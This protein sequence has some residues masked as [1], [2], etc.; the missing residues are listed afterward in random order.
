M[1]EDGVGL[2]QMRTVR[3]DGQLVV[4]RRSCRLVKHSSERDDAVRLLRDDDTIVE[5]FQMSQLQRV[6]LGAKTPTMQRAVE[7]V[8]SSGV[9]ATDFVQAA[10]WTEL[11]GKVPEAKCL[12]VIY[13]N[14]Y[15][16]F[17]AGFLSPILHPPP[18]LP[19]R[20]TGLSSAVWSH[21]RFLLQISELPRVEPCLRW[22]VGA[23]FRSRT[24]R[25]PRRRSGSGS[26][27]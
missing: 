17:E 8:P 3:Q 19:L 4:Q 15:L 21:T 23:C 11:N 10:K 2:Y 9:A 7:Y 6:V 1:A 5:T 24:R 18:K 26:S 22:C 16:D 25:S 12:T 20:P 14:Q 13:G 27:G